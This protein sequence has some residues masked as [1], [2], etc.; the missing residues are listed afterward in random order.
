MSNTQDGGRYPQFPDEEFERRHEEVREIMTD[1]DLEALLVY[2]DSGMHSHQHV[3]VHYLTDYLGHGS[4]YLVF[5][6]DPGEKPTLF[7]GVSNHGQYATEAS[8]IDD[9]RWG[10]YPMTGNVINR[11]REAGIANRV[12]LVGVSSRTDN[13]V[14]SGHLDAFRGAF[15]EVV[16][17]TPAFERLR[18]VKSE[19]EL[20][21]IRRGAELTDN[22]LRA[23]IETAEPG[24][25][26]YELRAAFE[27]A[28]IAEGGEQFVAFISSAPM[29]DAA[30]G[31]P[32]PWKEAGG[33]EV[34]YG[35]VI[36]TELSASYG[37]YPGQIHRPIAVGE[38]P[39]ATYR[40]MF[41]IAEEAYGTMLD[42]LRPGNTADDVVDAMAPLEESDFHIYDVN[43]HG[44]GTTL[45]PPFIG[46]HSEHS[47]Y[48]PA[49][50]APL[51]ANWEFEEHQVMVIQPN[52]V[53]PD[54][55]FGLQLG[56]TAIVQEGGPEVV[57]DVPVE[58][59][60]V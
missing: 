35:D 55:R 60:R 6:A 12:G 51:T 16:D 1:N 47:K 57:H 49:R 17:V 19:A 7:Y 50:K 30:P 53:T 44:F 15:G 5:F 40:D 36:G 34:R 58:F 28:H 41:E 13:V 31:G 26:E 54:E 37:G 24:V 33:R 2:G 56:T 25:T 22:G 9:V 52:L 38:A 20:D 45:Q 42:A 8:V 32:L 23:L 27:S 3:H 43:F 48:W 11:V 18:F 21:R 10:G 59:V 39:T 4:S 14:P 46:T 29:E